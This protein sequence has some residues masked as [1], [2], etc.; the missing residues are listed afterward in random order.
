MQ[1]YMNSSTIANS[2]STFAKFVAI[3][4][5]FHPL[6]K[7]GMFVLQKYPCCLDFARK[8]EIGRKE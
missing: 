6:L 5:I 3:F 1:Y 2:L 4:R 7:F 8:F